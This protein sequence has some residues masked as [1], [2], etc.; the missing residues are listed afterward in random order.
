MGE[1]MGVC[2][3][4]FCVQG[5]LNFSSKMYSLLHVHNHEHETLLVSLS[6]FLD[7]CSTY[8]EESE[9]TISTA[10]VNLCVRQTSI[11]ANVCIFGSL[12]NKNKQHS[13]TEALKYERHRDR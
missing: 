9:G 10:V 2:M 7:A 13:Q 11:P 6:R 5:S 4:V 3:W 8:K 1:A 12:Q